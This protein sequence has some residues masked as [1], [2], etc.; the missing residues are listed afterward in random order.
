MYCRDC[1]NYNDK[2]LDNCRKKGQTSPLR[3]ADELEC[4]TQKAESESPEAPDSGEGRM[5]TC[6]RCGRVLPSGMFGKRK[7]KGASGTIQMKVC[8][9]CMHESAAAGGK[10]RQEKQISG[11]QE[12]PKSKR[13]IK[14]TVSARSADVKPK[15]EVFTVEDTLRRATDDALAA[16]LRSRGWKGN[17]SKLLEI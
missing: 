2:S 4:F 3:K 7:K 8:R 1:Q 10:K 11:K 17:L 12:K 9:D 16:E 15:G 6:T 5:L 14:A 13:P